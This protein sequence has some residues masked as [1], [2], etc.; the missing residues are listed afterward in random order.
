VELHS[1]L[2]A[3]PSRAVALFLA[4]G[5]LRCPDCLDGV[6]TWSTKKCLPIARTGRPGNS[7][8]LYWRAYRHGN[9]GSFLGTSVVAT[10]VGSFTDPTEERLKE[11]AK[12][13]GYGL[14]READPERPPDSSDGV[15]SGMRSPILTATL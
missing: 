10:T 14:H 2:D 11:L 6:G 8:V 4:S 9:Q 12:E 1:P 3:Q 7:P 5:P 13:L 15:G